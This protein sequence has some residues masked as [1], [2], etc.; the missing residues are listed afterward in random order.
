MKIP[1]ET[2][3][4][5]INKPEE[6]FTSAGYFIQGRNT[7][8]TAVYSGSVHIVIFMYSIDIPLLCQ[9]HQQFK[10]RKTVAQGIGFFLCIKFIR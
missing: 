2:V 8:P 5:K 9:M 7:P 10:I 4:L 1:L 3:M 6:A